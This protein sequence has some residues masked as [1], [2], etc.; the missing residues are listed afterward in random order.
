M[1]ADPMIFR[2]NLEFI[3]SSQLLNILENQKGYLEKIKRG[4]N[5]ML[6]GHRRQSKS[7]V[8]NSKARIFPRTQNEKIMN[9]ESFRNQMTW[10]YYGK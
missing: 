9:H 7:F 2:H 1:V 3:L 6:E 4:V 5:S 10:V 8:P